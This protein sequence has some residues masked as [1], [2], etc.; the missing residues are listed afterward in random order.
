MSNIKYNPKVIEKMLNGE[1]T[2]ERIFNAFR[3]NTGE[4]K[5]ARPACYITNY[6][7]NELTKIPVDNVYTCSEE[8]SDCPFGDDVSLEDCNEYNNIFQKEN[9]IEVKLHL[10]GL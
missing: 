3:M 1:L 5:D 7:V 2:S 8:C 9:P 10:L 4:Y 6:G